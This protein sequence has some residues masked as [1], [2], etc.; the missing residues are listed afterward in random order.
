MV[1]KIVDDEEED[2]DDDEEEQPLGQKLKDGLA[3]AS[4]GSYAFR[5]DEDEDGKRKKKRKSKSK[6]ARMLYE[7]E[8]TGG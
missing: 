6:R 5:E 3:Q 2:D 7:E 4:R 8:F 1:F